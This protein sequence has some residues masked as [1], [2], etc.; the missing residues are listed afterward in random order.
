LLNKIKDIW[1]ELGEYVMCMAFGDMISQLK[2][3]KGIKSQ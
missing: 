1:L 2:N 3:I